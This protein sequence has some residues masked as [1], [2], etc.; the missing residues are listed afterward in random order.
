MNND[1][2][3]VL[4]SKTFH[5]NFNSG[6]FFLLKDHNLKMTYFSDGA[7]SQYKHKKSFSIFA[8]TKKISAFQLS[9]IFQPHH[10]GKGLV[11]N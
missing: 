8:T 7:A 6:I 10:V 9:A 4:F 11:T 3:V 2:T 5:T 1:T